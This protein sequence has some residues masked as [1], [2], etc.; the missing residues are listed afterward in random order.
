MA[1]YEIEP[2]VF[3]GRKEDTCIDEYIEE[4]IKYQKGNDELVVSVRGRDE[5]EVHDYEDQSATTHYTDVKIRTVKDV[6]KAHTVAGKESKASK[7]LSRLR[8]RDKKEPKTEMVS[9]EETHSYR[10]VKKEDFIKN[11]TRMT[12][13]NQQDISKLL[14]KVCKLIVEKGRPTYKMEQEKEVKP[15]ELSKVRKKQISL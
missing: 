15:E 6:V 8:K 12:N 14:E 1:E 2:G 3:Y 4:Y 9:K 10:D 5:L 7:L 11:P 13:E